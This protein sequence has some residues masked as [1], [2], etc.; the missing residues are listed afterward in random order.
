M[1]MPAKIQIVFKQQ[2]IAFLC[3][4]MFA[5]TLPAQ[6]SSVDDLMRA[7]EEALGGNSYGVAEKD[8]IAA[9]EMLEK[10]GVQDLRLARVLHDAATLYSV[11]GQFGKAEGLYESELVVR[12]KTLGA[13]HPDVVSGVAKLTNFYL[14]HD[15]VAKADRRVNLLLVFASKRLKDDE[16]IDGQLSQLSQFYQSHHEYV[17]AAGLLNKL[18]DSTKKIR[19]NSYLELAASLDSL[20]GMYKERGKFTVSEQL[21]KC[22]LQLRERG[23]SPAHLAVAASLDNLGNLY[24]ARKQYDLAE[25]L[26]KHALDISAGVLQPG[27]PEIASRV[28]ALAKSY[29]GLGRSSEA[30]ALYKQTLTDLEKTTASGARSTCSLGLA[31]VY[32]REGKYSLAEPLFKRA[33]QI[34]QANN[35]PQHESL[36]PILD[37]YAETLEKLGRNSQARSLREQARQI[38]GTTVANSAS[39]GAESNF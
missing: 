33:L 7:G 25:P 10:A 21:Y 9:R 27:R 39:H 1:I 34:C 24:L 36:L 5:S 30:Q 11:R 38:R 4:A 13:G 23:L 18:K 26:F 15:K 14:Q 3:V 20:G 22:A 19:A 32:V 16:N 29:V 31:S 6:A 2:I 28:D 35:G 17:E 8:F 37:S 12:E